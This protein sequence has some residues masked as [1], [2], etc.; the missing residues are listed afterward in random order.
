MADDQYKTG[1]L[2]HNILMYIDADIIKKSI[3]QHQKQTKANELDNRNK[4]SKFKEFGLKRIISLDDSSDRES[5]E[6]QRHEFYKSVKELITTLVSI[7]I[8]NSVVLL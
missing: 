2:H 5:E 4:F 7:T 1:G 8:I 3:K 6:R